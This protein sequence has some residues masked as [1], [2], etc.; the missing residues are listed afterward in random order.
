MSCQSSLPMLLAPS[1]LQTIIVAF[2]TIHDKSK[3]EDLRN[4]AFNVVTAMEAVV[5]GDPHTARYVHKDAVPHL[6]NVILEGIFG[7]CWNEELEDTIEM[8]SAVL[9]EMSEN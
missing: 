4:Q 6:K 9:D 3:D 2:K 7:L 5:A 8:L 1:T